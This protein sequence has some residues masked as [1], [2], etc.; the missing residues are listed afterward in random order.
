MQ[1]GTEHF[2]MAFTI[3][4]KLMSRVYASELSALEEHFPSLLVASFT[5]HE[6]DAA[7]RFLTRLLASSILVCVR[8]M[9]SRC[10]K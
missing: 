6:N 2:E 4:F 3:R 8:T 5:E 1:G 7:P 10:R 9:R